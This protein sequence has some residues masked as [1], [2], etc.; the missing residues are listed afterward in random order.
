MRSMALS[1]ISFVVCTT[2]EVANPCTQSSFISGGV[3]AQIIPGSVVRDIVLQSKSSSL[4]ASAVDSS[5]SFFWFFVSVTR[6]SS[7]SDGMKSWPSKSFV[8]V[9][10]EVRMSQQHRTELW[11]L[12]ELGHVVEQDAILSDGPHTHTPVL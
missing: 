5:S 2:P 6:L 12:S 1:D 3:T 11:P 8:V 10:L 7:R 9:V 4:P